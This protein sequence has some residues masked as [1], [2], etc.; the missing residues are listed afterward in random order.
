M[1]ITGVCQFVV[2]ENGQILGASI[3]G[4]Q[5]QELINP[6]ALAIGKNILVQDIADL[7][8]AY[9]GFSEILVKTAD[10]WHKYR[11][12][13]NYALQELLANFFYFR[14]DWKI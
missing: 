5:A 11:F 14:R 2:R 12:Q 1:A 6:I 3:L 10:Q 4:T 8:P 7:A 13:K 9:P